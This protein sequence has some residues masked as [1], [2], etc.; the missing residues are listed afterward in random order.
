MFQ[1]VV[2]E[3]VAVPPRLLLTVMF[4]GLVATEVKTR[5][6]F[7]PPLFVNVPMVAPL[8]VT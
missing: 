3:R 6:Y 4:T 8:E 1:F 7:P 2:T 5:L